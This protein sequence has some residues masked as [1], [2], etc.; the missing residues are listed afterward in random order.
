MQAV[1]G[2]SALEAGSSLL[3]YLGA[4]AVSNLLGSAL[5]QKPHRGWTVALVGAA[6]MVLGTALLSTVGGEVEVPQRLF[7]IEVFA[8]MGFGLSVATASVTAG[9]AAARRDSGALLSMPL[10]FRVVRRVEVIVG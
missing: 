10:E 1:N 5:A 2:Q 6:L 7:G 9:T 4:A 8:G 3:P